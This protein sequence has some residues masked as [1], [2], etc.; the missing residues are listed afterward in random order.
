MKYL[1]FLRAGDGPVI[2]EGVQINRVYK[3]NAKDPT[4]SL[5][6]LEFWRGEELVAEFYAEAVAGWARGDTGGKE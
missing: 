3:V 2:I 4:G 5:E 1:I 6:R